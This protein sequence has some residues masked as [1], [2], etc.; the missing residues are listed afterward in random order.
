MCLS[1]AETAKIHGVDFYAY[2]KKLLTDLPNLNFQ[3]MPEIL[4]DYLPW[5]KNILLSCGKQR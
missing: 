2:L 4:D 5:S 3:Q 1:L